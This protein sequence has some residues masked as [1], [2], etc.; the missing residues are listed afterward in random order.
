M[1][2]STAEGPST[3][4]TK[5]DSAEKVVRNESENGSRNNVRTMVEERELNDQ[6]VRKSLKKEV[7]IRCLK[8]MSICALEPV[9]FI[10]I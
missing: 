2:K 7:S 9:L 1:D 3:S 6:K 4:H 8:C 5:D 10:K